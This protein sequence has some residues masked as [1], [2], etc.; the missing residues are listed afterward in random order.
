MCILNMVGINNGKN[1]YEKTKLVKEYEEISREQKIIT[2]RTVYPIIKEKITTFSEKG[3]LNIISLMGLRGTGKTT[4]LNT[5][6]KDFDALYTSGDF[7]NNY[8]IEIKELVEIADNLKRKI[9]IIDEITY[10]KD[11]EMQLKIWGDLYQKYLFIISSSSALNLKELSADLSRRIDLYKIDPMSFSE[12]LFIKYNIKLDISEELFNTIFK[13][14]N[15]KKKFENLSKLTLKLPKELREYYEE[16]KYKQ[17]PFLLN[18]EFPLSKVKDVIDK[19][20]YK[21]IPKHDT[22]YSS[23]LPK[24]EKIL[25]FLTVNEKTNYDNISRNTG[26]KRDLVEKIFNLLVSSQLIFVAKDIVPT[27]EFKI[28]KKILF[29]VP[30]LRF[31][32]DQIHLDSIIGFGREDMFTYIIRKLN[33]DY[34]YNY[35]QKDFDFMVGNLKFE[36]GG[37]NKELKNDLIVISEYSKLKIKENSLEIP[38]ELF[39]LLIK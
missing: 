21:D 31:S 10:L 39:S 25:R 20:I 24:I 11:W 27:R 6:S 29:N 12:F 17:F 7:L 35:K 19:V 4:I 34:A 32:L 36:V 1:I 5:I 33:L 28:T 26:I 13:E 37:K 14:K 16:F 9:I 30:S 23:N 8:N 3:G 22:L 18:E 38:I 2:Q 15:V